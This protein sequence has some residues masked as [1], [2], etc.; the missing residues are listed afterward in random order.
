MYQDNILLWLQVNR[1]YDPWHLR[2]FITLMYVLT[3]N[4][5]KML[6]WYIFFHACLYLWVIS[7]IYNW[8]QHYVIKFV[9]DFQQ[10]TGRWFSLGTPVSSTN[11]TDLHNIAEILLKVALNTIT[12]TL[13]P[14]YTN[15]YHLESGL[16]S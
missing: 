12:L 16:I 2:H 4:H 7:F 14:L 15:C 10:V 1:Q 3:C 13:N 6:S 8:I 11:K 9:S 5:N